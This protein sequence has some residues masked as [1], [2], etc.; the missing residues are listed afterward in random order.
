MFFI[1]DGTKAAIFLGNRAPKQPSASCPD[2]ETPRRRELVAYSLKRMNGCSNLRPNWLD[3]IARDEP[4]Q[5]KERVFVNIGANKGYLLADFL[6]RWTV[7]RLD[8]LNPRTRWLKLA[9]LFSC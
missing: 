7:Q 6:L 8:S 9:W 2:D 4:E 3:H 5:Q 1:L